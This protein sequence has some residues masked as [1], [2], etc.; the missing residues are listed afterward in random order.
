MENI[1]SIDI[2]EYHQVFK[3]QDLN[4]VN[5]PIILKHHPMLNLTII[6][7]IFQERTIISSMKLKLYNPILLMYHANQDVHLIL[8]KNNLFGNLTVM[9]KGKLQ[10]LLKL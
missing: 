5:L 10:V 1:N 7:L 4:I 3:K 9:K 6:H 8:I 2:K